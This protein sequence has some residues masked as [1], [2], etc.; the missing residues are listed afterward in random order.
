MGTGHVPEPA[1]HSVFG[2]NRGMRVVVL[3]FLACLCPSAAVTCP[4]LAD[5]RPRQ[6]ITGASLNQPAGQN[7]LE[8]NPEPGGPAQYAPS[9]QFPLE[10]G[11]RELPQPGAAGL[12]DQDLLVHRVAADGRVE[13]LATFPRGGVAALT[14][15][16]D[17]RLVAA[18]QY[19]PENSEIIRV[20]RGGSSRASRQAAAPAP[21]SD[22]G[23]P[24]PARWAAPWDPP[25]AS[26]RAAALE[27]PG[28]F[29]R[30]P[31]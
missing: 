9:I 12:W 18:H 29:H 2:Y 21:G 8:R 23:S 3:L 31:W 30:S 13:R 4:G 27:P 28:S 24:G 16:K 11:T 19:F 20:R 15:M 26:L 22:R 10:A 7:R 5:E 6:G 14:R 1:G 25:A 17:G